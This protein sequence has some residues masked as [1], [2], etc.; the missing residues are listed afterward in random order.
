MITQSQVIGITGASLAGLA[1]LA[2]LGRK[3]P[4]PA[5]PPIKFT[6]GDITYHFTAAL[7]EICPVLNLEL[8]VCKQVET[9]T[10]TDELRVLWGLVDLAPM[11]CRYR[12]RSPIGSMSACA[13]CGNS[14]PSAT[15]SSCM[16][17]CYA[18]LYRPQ[19]T[20]MNCSGWSSGAG[21]AGRRRN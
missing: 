19:S 21:A 12:C 9:F 7:P 17:P 5:E 3:Q 4:P 14:K 6:N 11:P 10:Q 20:P 18:R 13:T 16:H 15:A 2:Y 1:A 8:A